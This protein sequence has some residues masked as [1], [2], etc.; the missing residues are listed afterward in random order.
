MRTHAGERELAA[1]NQGISAARK[2]RP[3]T[4]EVILTNGE[5]GPTPIQ[6]VAKV[7]HHRDELFPG[8]GFIRTNMALPSRSAVR[9]SYVKV[10]RYF[11]KTQ[12]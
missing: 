9:F 3:P 5:L 1:E 7:E 2:A 4:L 11:G 10:C 6:I 12:E 8:V